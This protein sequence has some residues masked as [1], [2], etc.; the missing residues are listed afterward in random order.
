MKSKPV[1]LEFQIA[2]CCIASVDFSTRFVMSS[3]VARSSVRVSVFLVTD[4]IWG[5]FFVQCGVNP[6][7]VSFELP[8]P[9][10]DEPSVQP[11]GAREPENK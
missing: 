3:N 10:A 1:D 9:S 2:L 11:S 5:G 7:R 6:D 8:S 4:T